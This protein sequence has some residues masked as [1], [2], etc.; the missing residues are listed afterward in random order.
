MLQIPF[1]R[2]VKNRQI[3]RKIVDEWLAGLGIGKNWDMTANQ[4][5]AP[6]QGLKIF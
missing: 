6:F 5:G 2:S 1:V 4:Y 3:H